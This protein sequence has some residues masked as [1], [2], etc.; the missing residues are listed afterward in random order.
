MEILKT[1][2]RILIIQTAFLGDAIL[3]L[4]MI[5]KIK[6][7]YPVSL[8]DVVS[9][10]QT[11][12]VF[13][14]SPYVY[15]VYSYDKKGNQRSILS[16][17]KFALTLKK[18]N[19]TRIYS[20]HRSF[21]TSLLV[22]LL[23]NVNSFGFDTASLNFVYEN[24]IKYDN[25]IH[26]VARNLKLLGL[27]IDK[28]NWK[29]LP[30]LK[31]SQEVKQKIQN[32]LKN[33]NNPLVA[34]APG[35]VWQTK[36]YPEEYF[37]TISNYLV[38]ENY[39]VVFIGGQSDYEL[40]NRLSSKINEDSLSFAG[41]LSIT[42]S[43]EL[44]RNCNLLISNDSAPTHLGMVANIPVLTIY[45]STIPGFGFF[46]Y[47]EYSFSISFDGLECKP[48]GI[49]GR[50][51]CPIKTFDCGYKLLPDKVIEKIEEVLNSKEK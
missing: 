40:C 1:T 44:L 42:E 5:Q 49:H 28:E 4:P 25:K 14:N 41:N 24:K 8:I 37:E 29:V 39:F 46:P 50:K 32:L 26:E 20:P 33:I 21:R 3:T 38:K 30:E 11:K 16:L 27:S 18:N 45:C 35:S 31:I 51:S 10:P 7:I 19:Y 34:I 36:K 47:N 22:Y 2:E 48:C 12:E 13:E 17:I 23:D 6:E 43:V 15:K 9:I